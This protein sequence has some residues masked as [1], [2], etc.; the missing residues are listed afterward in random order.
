MN[1]ICE[2]LD[3]VDWGRK[4][5]VNFN[6]GKIQLVLFGW[7]NNTGAID[8]KTDGSVLEEKSSFKMFGLTFS[9]K[10]DWGSYTISIV[11]TASRKIGALIFSLKFLIPKVSP[12]LY[13]STIWPCM[14]CCCHVWGYASSC[15]LELLDKLQ[16]RTCRTVG[17]SLNTSLEP[18]VHLGN[19]ASLSL[20][21]R[22]YFGRYSSEL[23]Q[24]VLLPFCRARSTGYSGRLRD[25]FCHHF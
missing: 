8:A 25:F 1:L 14:E 24:L 6:A 5:R 20:F 12:R 19:V 2:I 16:N 4:W 13:K 11:K 3:T 9:S 23:A 7:S 10:L 15:Y 21:C 17:P 22:S 18:L